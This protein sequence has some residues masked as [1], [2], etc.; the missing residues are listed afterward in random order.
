MIMQPSYTNLLM[1]SRDVA[2]LSTAAPP[3]TEL[4]DLARH[5][6]ES[7]VAPRCGKISARPP[8]GEDRKAEQR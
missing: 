7:A 5:A 1:I 2:G 4:L 6:A 3:R 8:S